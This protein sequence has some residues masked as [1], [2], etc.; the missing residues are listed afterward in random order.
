MSDPLK[1]GWKWKR[2]RPANQQNSLIVSAV[3]WTVGWPLNNVMPLEDVRRQKFSVDERHRVWFQSAESGSDLLSKRKSFQV[4]DE[5]Q[6]DDVVLL[7]IQKQSRFA[8]TWCSPA[9]ADS[10]TTFV[11]SRG[12]MNSYLAYYWWTINLATFCL[13][14]KIS[15]GT[16]TLW[17]VTDRLTLRWRKNSKL[18]SKCLL[19]SF[20]FAA[21]FSLN[22]L[23]ESRGKVNICP[24][25]SQQV[26]V[27]PSTPVRNG[28]GSVQ[29]R[30]KKFETESPNK[31]RHSKITK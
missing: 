5:F 15:E 8:L 21:A 7:E 18:V 26:S 31:L 28:P 10:C 25:S 20:I 6:S 27:F 23:L 29:Q 30:F 1:D 12:D 14:C 19:V 13:F 16:G 4:H 9:L 2:W 11:T 22:Y 3:I 17:E 24:P